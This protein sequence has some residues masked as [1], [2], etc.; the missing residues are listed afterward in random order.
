MLKIFLILLGISSSAFAGELKHRVDVVSQRDQFFTVEV[1]VSGID[2]KKQLLYALHIEE[3]VGQVA[4]QYTKAGFL[5]NR[6]L[7]IRRLDKRLS[8][9][10]F[11]FD[12][13]GILVLKIKDNKIIDVE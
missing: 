12:G 7:V 13:I 11:K 1:M 5:N 8:R 10:G 9:H 2:E 3:V 6:D 4:S